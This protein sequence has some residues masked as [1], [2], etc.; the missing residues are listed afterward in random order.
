MGALPFGGCGW[1]PGARAVAAL[2]LQALVPQPEGRAGRGADLA[3]RTAASRRTARV[4][5]EALATT[6][7][8]PARV[9][10]HRSRQPAAHEAVSIQRNYGGG[11]G[12]RARCHGTCAPHEAGADVGIL[13]RHLRRE[14]PRPQR[15]VTVRVQARH[16]GQYSPGAP[17]NRLRGKRACCGLP[18]W[19]Q[20]HTHQLQHCAASVQPGTRTSSLA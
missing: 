2:A 15:L 7:T 19:A 10:R 16:A 1:W 5:A 18:G 20:H 17:N 4:P 9:A 14:R 3:G 12:A 8:Q 11:A 13:R 6:Y